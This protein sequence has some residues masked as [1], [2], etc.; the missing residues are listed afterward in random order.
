MLQDE[1]ISELE[2]L[3]PVNDSDLI[4]VVDVSD[5][6]MSASGTTKKALKSEL[7]GDKGDTGDNATVDVG[8]TTTGAPG[9]N[10]SVTNSGTV[11]DAIFNFTI[12]RGDVGATGPQGPQGPAGDG[13]VTGPSGATSD[14]IA[15]YN[16]ATGKI[17]K[18]GGSKISDLI[19]KTTLSTARSIMVA[20]S[21]NTPTE[22]AMSTNSVVGRISGDVVNIPIDSDLASTSVGDD[23]VPSAKA[24]KT[25][26]DTKVAANVAITGATKT[27]VTYDD[28]GLVTSGADATTAD[29]A[30]ST[31]KR[32]VTDAQ[33]T[34]IGNTS[35]TNTGDQTLPVKASGA[36]LD[37]GTDD[38][39][40]A[41][42]KAINDSHNVPSVAPGTSGNVMTSN[43]TDW[44][45]STPSSSGVSANDSL[46]V[47]TSQSTFFSHYII[48]STSF[49]WSV[50]SCTITSHANGADF[51][52]TAGGKAYVD[53]MPFATTNMDNASAFRF[54]N[55]KDV[56]FKFALGVRDF[57]ADGNGK[58]FGVGLV[59]SG[60][61]GTMHST[62]SVVKA[63]KF[64]ITNTQIITH[65]ADG[66]NKTQNTY[67]EIDTNNNWNLYEIVYNPGTDVKFY[68]NG[69]LK[70]THTTNLPTGTDQ[71]NLAISSEAS[72][73]AFTSN[74]IF[75]SQ[76]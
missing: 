32:Y 27:K 13:D 55:D 10:A 74:L 6:T 72:L 53:I 25:Y 20:Q 18:D 54:D 42:A 17:I 28:K 3:S 50:T 70:A 73:T 63:I 65:T 40:F 37:T 62:T 45:S 61:E 66:S 15:I 41:T 34:V 57:T 1:K 30:D 60:Q 39:K 12:P 67:T 71:C 68:V 5:T 8:T 24:T 51:S 58:Y 49:G 26:A 35:G 64:L 48:P 43:G 22:L 33:L 9:T 16:G 14:N 31:N 52:F 19:P 2:S 36:E 59:I 29:I 56:K 46:N 4:V 23:T 69:T 21:A 76:I 44:V 47:D 7:K 75:A 38:A 11:S